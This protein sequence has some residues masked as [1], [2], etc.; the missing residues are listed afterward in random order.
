M[1][2]SPSVVAGTFAGTAALRV[3]TEQTVIR[4]RVASNIDLACSATIWMRMSDN[5]DENRQSQRTYGVPSDCRLQEQ[6]F[7]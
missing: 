4:S 7:G 2:M 1:L 5:L 3:S 6:S